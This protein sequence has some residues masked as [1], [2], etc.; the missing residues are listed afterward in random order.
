MGKR[1]P[2]KK[3]N[4]IRKWWLMHYLTI[5]QLDRIVDE[6]KRQL[7][8][9][10]MKFDA[11]LVIAGLVA[12]ESRRVDDDLFNANDFIESFKLEDEYEEGKEEVAEAPAAR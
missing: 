10:S 1:G 6:C 7:P 2:K 11:R 8:L 4:M 3:L 9:L 12:R 5:E